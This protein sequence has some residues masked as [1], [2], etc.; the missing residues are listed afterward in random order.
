MMACFHPLAAWK[1]SDGKVVFR[2]TADSVVSLFLPCGRCNG[3]RLERARQWSIRIM[4]E[5][6]F[7]EDN[8]FITLTYRP[9]CVPP[10]GSLRYEDFQDFMKALRHKFGPTRFFMCGEY[11]ER[12]NRPH[13][14]AG[15]FGQAFRADRKFWR[16]SPAGFRL[17]R[18]PTLEKLWPHGNSEIGDLT[19]ESAAYMARYT[20]KKVTGEPAE[21]HYEAVDFETGEVSRRKPEFCRMSLKPGIGAKWFDKYGK[22]AYNFDRVVV[23]GV[24]GKP[25]RYYDTLLERSDPEKLEQVKFE[26]EVKARLG[27]L[28]NTDERLAVRETVS[29]AR[30]RY[31]RRSHE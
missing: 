2:E 30:L 9:E 24:A 17:Y 23:K 3:C 20:F 22:D 28:D 5:A 10:F 21:K 26:R 8:S 1:T 19:R 12:F 31:F 25:P 14:H 27:A 7:Y 6:S 18:S 16:T 13:Y 11:G 4:H 29:N 15:I